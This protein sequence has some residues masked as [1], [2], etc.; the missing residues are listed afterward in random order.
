MDF[1]GSLI[2][3]GQTV[4]PLSYVFTNS[5]S[6]VPNSRLD[7]GSFQDANGILQRNVID[8]APST[9]ELKT[10]PM[11]NIELSEMMRLMKGNYI[12]VN[13]RKVL[14]T[15]YCPDMDEYKEGTF[16]VPDIAFPINRVDQKTNTVYYN[17]F[18][19]KFIEY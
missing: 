5:Y 2:K 14:L 11:T 4:F 6:I 9:I 19:L 15:Y 10:K 1:N 17:S 3:I 18:T 7:M 8:H 12:N 13:E 16:Y